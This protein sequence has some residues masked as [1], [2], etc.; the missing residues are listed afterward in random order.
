[1]VQ[2]ESISCQHG[3]HPAAPLTYVGRR[4]PCSGAFR[5]GMT[6]AGPGTRAAAACRRAVKGRGSG[7]AGLM[8]KD[9]WARSGA[10][11]RRRRGEGPARGGGGKEEWAMSEV[12]AAS[13]GERSGE[14]APS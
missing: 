2:P 6:R 7:S 13:G 10:A 3:W 11:P 5:G 4:R 1:M 8:G 12:R 9:S 14:G